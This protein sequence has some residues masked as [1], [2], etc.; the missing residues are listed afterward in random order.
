MGKIVKQ[1]R[2]L[3]VEDQI[4]L[5]KSLE[6]NL[7][8]LGYSVSAIASSAEEAV[9]QATETHPDLVLMD[10]T[11]Q[12]EMD[13]IEAAE[14]IRS[15]S[16]I[17]VIYLTGYGD[18]Q[19]LQRAKITG[20]LG[21]LIKPVRIT[22]LRSTIEIALCK[23]RMEEKIQIRLIREAAIAQA[24]RLF[25]S[26]EGAD[27]Q[28]ILKNLAEAF[29][30]EHAYL[31]RLNE[32][33][34]TESIHEWHCKE[35]G[36]GTS[37]NGAD[38]IPFPSWMNKL[39]QGESIVVQDG[40]ETDP[41][42][43][44]SVLGESC[45]TVVAV[46]IHSITG[47]FT[48]I[49]RFDKAKDNRKWF[50]EDMQAF[51][52]MADMVGIHWERKRMEE[53]LLQAVESAEMANRAKSEFLANISH[54]IRTPMNAIM[55]MTELALDTELTNEQR[56]YLDTVKISADALLDLLNDILDFSKIE[57]GHLRH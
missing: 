15:S 14:R 13:G 20:P 21:Y 57:A 47:K 30:M 49:M 31:V 2:I 6:C 52:V 46:P 55:G 36:T 19:T 1:P 43:T 48:G 44:K 51:R 42:S 32:E 27:L 4:R 39:R 56:E 22:E 40:E 50:S 34:Q 29:S 53:E 37:S 16:D 9:R 12:R 28:E 24:S 45:D 35:S 26:P 17:P 3:I 33:G 38:L 18:D 11:L 41:P 23:H 54:E 5:A 8:A 25:I 7:R 10:I